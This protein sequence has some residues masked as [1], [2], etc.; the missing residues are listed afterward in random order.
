[1]STLLFRGRVF[2]S[3][4]LL[5][6]RG[7]SSSLAYQMAF[8]FA[9]LIPFYRFYNYGSNTW[10][11][12]LQ[13]V[14]MYIVCVYI[15]IYISVHTLYIIIFTLHITQT[16][17][18]E[19]PFHQVLHLSAYSIQK[20]LLLTDFKPIISSLFQGCLVLCHVDVAHYSPIDGHLGLSPMFYDTNI[21]VYI[22]LPTCWCFSRIDSSK[23]SVRE[24]P[25]PQI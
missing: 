12:K 13:A 2:V 20:K 11:L 24:Y 23:W 1:M 14:S 25:F 8:C 15:C 9:S 7:G 21:L 17:K 6:G 19:S 18:S 4:D 22:P 3:S 10:S 5:V 16:E